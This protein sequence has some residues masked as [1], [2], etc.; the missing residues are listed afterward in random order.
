MIF[1]FKSKKSYLVQYSDELQGNKFAEESFTSQ[2]Y[3]GNDYKVEVGFE[4]MMYERLNDESSGNLTDIQQGAMLDKKFEPT[5]GDPLLFYPIWTETSDVI[6]FDNLDDTFSDLIRYY[7]PSNAIVN[8]VTG[9]ASQTIN[10]GI[11]ADEYTQL[12]PTPSNDLYTKYYRNYV[13]NLF[14]RNSRKTNVSAYLPLNVILKYRLNDI[15]IIGTME[16]RINSIKTNLLTNKSDLELYNLQV[17]TSQSLNGQRQELER[18]QNLETTSKTSSSISVQWDAIQANNVFNYEIYLDDEFYDEV[19]PGTTQLVNNLE[20]D[21]TYKISVRA[22]Y[23]IGTGFN[24][25]FDTDL[26]E[27]TL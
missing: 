4:K 21:T 12:T 14:A 11:E 15:F 18:V 20:T 7:R 5:I 13:A 19:Y 24:S 27:T 25:S 9:F 17:N 3:D 8:I 2:Q 23:N 26:F 6:K 22:L 1:K 10:F 16:Y